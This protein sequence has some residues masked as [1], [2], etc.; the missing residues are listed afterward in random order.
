MVAEE[1]AAGLEIRWRDEALGLRVVVDREGVAR[2]ADL[3]ATAGA[4]AHG[5]T[6][7]GAVEAGV[8]IESL[9]ASEPGSIGLPLLDVV[10]AGSGPPLVR[11]ALL[12][13]GVGNRM[14]YVGHSERDS[15]PMVRTRSLLQDTSTWPPRDR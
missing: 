8:G 12:R 11:E 9:L 10:V 13:I 1:T 2:L 14:R 15:A 4:P 6:A 7:N 3:A 5:P